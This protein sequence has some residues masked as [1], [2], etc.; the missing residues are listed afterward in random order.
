M[1]LM[2]WCHLCC[3]RANLRSQ[4]EWVWKLW[5]TWLCMSVLASV[6]FRSIRWNAWRS[7]IIPGL[8]RSGKEDWKVG[9]PRIYEDWPFAPLVSLAGTCWWRLPS[10]SFRAGF[11]LQERYTQSSPGRC[12][13]SLHS[14]VRTV[15]GVFPALDSL[16][17]G[18]S[19]WSQHWPVLHPSMNHRENT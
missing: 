13:P 9:R 15:W 8:I 5:F 11:L 7:R 18:V 1:A 12:K 3:Y 17:E 6:T 16:S 10:F 14:T 4:K 2:Y 19:M